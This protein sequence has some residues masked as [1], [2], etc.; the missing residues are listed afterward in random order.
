MGQDP[1]KKKPWRAGETP[2][3]MKILRNSTREPEPQLVRRSTSKSQPSLALAHSAKL[4]ANHSSIQTTSGTVVSGDGGIS[5]REGWHSQR[6]RRA[7]QAQ[8]LIDKELGKR[9]WE[10]VWTWVALGWII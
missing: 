7:R 3:I 8:V 2:K 4:S 1:C 10:A 5:A 6:P 9:R